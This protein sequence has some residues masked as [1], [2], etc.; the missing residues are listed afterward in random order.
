MTER[1]KIY[2]TH[3]NGGRPFKVVIAN[4]VKA[5]FVIERPPFDQYESKPT[6]ECKAPL[7]VFVGSHPKDYYC[8]YQAYRNN[9]WVKHTGNSILVEEDQETYVYIGDMIQRFK[10]KAPIVR[11][12]S[13]IG[14]SDVPYP[15]A[16]DSDGKYYLMV[17]R[18]ILTKE[19]LS[20]ASQELLDNYDDPYQIAYNKEASKGALE[21]L[22]MDLLHHGYH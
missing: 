15:Y 16:V 2:Y 18:S 3:W 21:P 12:E 8:H 14:N 17:D 4:H 13:P 9:P 5:Y 19:K 22:G 20:E 10:T 7:S 11:Y 6:Y 1:K